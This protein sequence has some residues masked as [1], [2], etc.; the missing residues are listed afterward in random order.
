MKKSDDK[1][2]LKIVDFA[3]IKKISRKEAKKRAQEVLDIINNEFRRNLW[4]NNCQ[5]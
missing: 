3:T 2:V 5:M 4:K 1:Y